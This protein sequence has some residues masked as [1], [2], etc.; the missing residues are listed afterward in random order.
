MAEEV[1]D[2]QITMI[3]IWSQGTVT[4][5]LSF[6]SDVLRDGDVSVRQRKQK[7][8]KSLSLNDEIYYS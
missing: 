6:S 8:Q 7:Q 3:Q 2:V 5:T 4:I 1:F